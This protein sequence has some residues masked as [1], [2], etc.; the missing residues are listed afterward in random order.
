MHRPATRYTGTMTDD[1]AAEPFQATIAAWLPVPDGPRALAYYQAAFG[2]VERYTLTDDNGRVVVA[3]LTV[4]GAELW[5]GEDS[6]P[7]PR[8]GGRRVRLVLTVE[9]PDRIFAQAVA[10]GGTEVFPVG[11]DH[12]WRVGRLVDPFGHHWEVGRPLPAQ[13]G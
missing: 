4:G 8:A 2:A 12:G 3:R 10:A 5:L 9:H 11:E 1:A 7:E 13:D 6:E